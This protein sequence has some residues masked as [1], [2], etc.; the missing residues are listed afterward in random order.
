M[1]ILE[2][3][4][5]GKNFGHLVAVNALDLTVEDGEIRGLI[6]PNGSGKTTTFNLISGFLT[7][8]RGRVFFQGQEITGLPAHVMAKKGLVR[9]F[10]LTALFRELTAQQNVIMAC[11]LHT[12]MGL[13]EQFFQ[14]AR[15]RDREREIEERALALLDSMGIA[16][17]KD[18]IAGDLPHGH[19]R[20]L[21]IANALATEPRMLLLDEP[22]GG[23]TPTEAKETM[24]RIKMVRDRGV[25][26]LLV[27]HDMKTVM[28][29]CEKITCMNFGNKIAE[30]TPQE[31]SLHR[32]VIEAYLGGGTEAC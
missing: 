22:V 7:P 21:G 29:T 1:A 10:Q 19:Q 13:L 31:I 8:T 14:G 30:G 15:T 5:L 4:G 2:L 25:T 23:M 20:A 11:H 6:G 18:E 16:D 26:I 27:E 12:G 24:D 32:D 3:N 9:T 17:K 28:T